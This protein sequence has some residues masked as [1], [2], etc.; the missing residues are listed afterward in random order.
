M[1]KDKDRTDKVVKVL[2]RAR[3]KVDDECDDEDDPCLKKVVAEGLDRL[4]AVAQGQPLD[5]EEEA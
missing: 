3:K 5:Y 4:I 2:E 1:P